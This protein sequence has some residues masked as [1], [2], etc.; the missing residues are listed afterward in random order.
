MTKIRTAIEI[1]TF[2]AFMAF[3]VPNVY[4]AFIRP[5]LF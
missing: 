3:V 5:H 1:A 2:T 4:V